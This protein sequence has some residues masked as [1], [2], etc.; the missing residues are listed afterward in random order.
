MAKYPDNKYDLSFDEIIDILGNPCVEGKNQRI[1]CCSRL[2]C[3]WWKA[4]INIDYIS[5][6]YCE[7]CD[8]GDLLVLHLTD[9]TINN[10]P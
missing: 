10:N 8:N 7:H 3:N 9:R 1:W 4:D 6:Q 2:H 5:N